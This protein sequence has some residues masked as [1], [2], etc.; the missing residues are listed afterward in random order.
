L[1]KNLWEFPDYVKLPISQV[2]DLA[3]KQG[4]RVTL[5]DLVASGYSLDV[6]QQ[7]FDA[8]QQKGLARRPDAD[9]AS[10][11]LGQK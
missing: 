10:I 1:Q 9:R 6:A 5:Q 3:Q 8:I 2:I 4:G 7:T 11:L